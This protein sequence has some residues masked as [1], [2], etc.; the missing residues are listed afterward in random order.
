MKYLKTL[1]YGILFKS[2]K[3]NV[4]FLLN[5]G[6]LFIGSVKFS[7]FL[8]QSS[9]QINERNEK[10]KKTYDVDGFRVTGYENPKNATKHRFWSFF[11]RQIIKIV[12][13]G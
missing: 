12:Q 9:R 2:V 10:I 6:T 1:Y 8:P 3:N 4:F 13:N 5:F 11:D 7:K